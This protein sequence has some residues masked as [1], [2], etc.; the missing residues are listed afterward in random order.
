MGPSGHFYS[1]I[2][3]TIGDEGIP[4]VDGLSM[5]HL[6]ILG[7]HNFFS[8]LFHQYHGDDITL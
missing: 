6:G 1:Y 7:R 4:R 2:G 3:L 8:Y 5:R